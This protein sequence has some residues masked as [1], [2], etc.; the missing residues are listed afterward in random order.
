MNMFYD[1]EMNVGGGTR[2]LEKIHQIF[3]KSS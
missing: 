3:Q 2:K 1:Y